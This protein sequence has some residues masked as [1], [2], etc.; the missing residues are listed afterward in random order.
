MWNASIDAFNR[1]NGDKQLWIMSCGFG[2]INY[3]EN[4]SGY[5]ATFRLRE[6]DSLYN[7]DYF[8]RLKSNDVKKQWWNLLTERGILKTNNPQSIHELVNNSKPTDAVVIAAGSDYYEAIYDD[9]NKIKVSEE[10]PNIALVG[11]K[12]NNRRYEPNIPRKLGPYIQSFSNGRRL[13]EFLGCSAI[14]VQ[15]KSASYL[16][17]KYN[18]TGKLKYIFP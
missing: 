4:I 16:I 1:I 12:R 18:K 6:N 5:H 10:L 7:P 17:E 2:F 14:Q 9:L 11:I 13:R 15:L 3:E 8:Y